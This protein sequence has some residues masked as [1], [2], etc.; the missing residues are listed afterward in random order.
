MK[1]TWSVMENNHGS[2][3]DNSNMWE[4]EEEDSETEASVGYS[5]SQKSETFLQHWPS[6]RG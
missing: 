4:A 1:T 3:M 2:G 6:R 5:S